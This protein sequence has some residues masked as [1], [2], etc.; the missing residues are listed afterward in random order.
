MNA[1]FPADGPF[2]PLASVET[3][4]GESGGAA[5]V[6]AVSEDDEGVG[7]EDIADS[8]SHNLSFS[9]AP[10]PGVPSP[11]SSVYDDSG[12]ALEYFI[13]YSLCQYTKLKFYS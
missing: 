1:L 13:I 6:G 3:G 10:P 8:L 11:L 12:S 7:D 2:D 9:F 5:D 4:A